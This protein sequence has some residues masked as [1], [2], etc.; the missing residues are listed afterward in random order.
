M[1]GNPSAAT[2]FIDFSYDLS[3]HFFDALSEALQGRQDIAR[4]IWRKLNSLEQRIYLRQDLLK[5]FQRNQG[6]LIQEGE[7]QVDQALEDLEGLLFRRIQWLLSDSDLLDE[8][9]KEIREAVLKSLG[10]KKQLQALGKPLR[11]AWQVEGDWK[12]EVEVLANKLQDLPEGILGSVNVKT[13]IR[14]YVWSEV[15][16][17]GR[18]WWSLTPE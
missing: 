12:V 16:H 2:I 6:R 1:G 13:T 7:F 9:L 10:L 15:E 11:H 14:N 8:Q 18:K 17:E 3:E 5:Y 4:D